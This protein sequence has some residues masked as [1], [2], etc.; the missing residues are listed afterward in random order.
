[1]EKSRRENWHPQLVAEGA[2]TLQAAGREAALVMFKT[3]PS[4]ALLLKASQR[5]AASALRTILRPLQQVPAGFVSV[6]PLDTKDKQSAMFKIRLEQST[7]GAGAAWCVDPHSPNAAMATAI[8][9]STLQT[10][11]APIF[12]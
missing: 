11:I 12:L 6:L 4:W 3:T 5:Q 2:E 9:T 7:A 1:M 10:L 8:T